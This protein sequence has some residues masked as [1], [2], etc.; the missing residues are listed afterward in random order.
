M[1]VA[2]DLPPGE[3]A[4]FIEHVVSRRN[5]PVWPMD[6]HANY[7]GESQST[8]PEERSSEPGG[9]SAVVA[10]PTTGTAVAPAT[11]E[12]IP[13]EGTIST[14]LSGAPASEPSPP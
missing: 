6:R 5:H 10:A 13:G 12:G 7:A 11:T 4:A 9:G 3:E 2:P 8:S 1:T 14:N